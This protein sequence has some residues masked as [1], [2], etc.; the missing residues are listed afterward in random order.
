MVDDLW[1]MHLYRYAGDVWMDGR[2]LRFE[3]GWAGFTPPGAQ[4]RYRFEGTCVHVF[5]HLLWP[6]QGTTT[7]LP[8]VFPVGSRFEPLWEG[9]EEAI[10]WR[11]SRRADVRAWDVALSLA[12][13]ALAPQTETHAA[14]EAALAFIEAHLAQPIGAH[15]A[16][17]AAFVS[18]NH[19]C[20]LFR[21]HLGATVMGTIRGRR[22][23]RARHLLVHTSLPV[24]QIAA[25]V[26]I[27]DLQ[28]FNK[29]MRLETGRSP[30]AIRS[31]GG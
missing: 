11:G 6:I 30:R 16:A 14:V 15:D 21:T 31:S 8:L 23:E 7:D 20:R 22:V 29:T 17:R 9:L 12:E 27:D 13:A 25:Q 18:H 10:P 3:S 4:M 26:G 19:L 5:A 28:R 1:G 24:K 2:P